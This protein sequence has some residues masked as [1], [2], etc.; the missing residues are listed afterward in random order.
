MN[1]KK[2]KTIRQV[3]R[4]VDHPQQI[5]P[6][7][8]SSDFIFPSDS[9]LQQITLSSL[10]IKNEQST[11]ILKVDGDIFDRW[12]VKRGDFIIVD[13][14]SIPEMNSLVLVA[15]N[16]ELIIK[17]LCKKA[18]TFFLESLTKKMPP[19]KI[20]EEMHVEILGV[21]THIIHSFV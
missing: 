10:L 19:Q 5:L 9:D 20:V 2:E 17:R 18:Q 11:Y 21:I 15:D 1:N 6:L 12:N 16:N 8:S 3:F 4:L 14:Y 13:K 7:F